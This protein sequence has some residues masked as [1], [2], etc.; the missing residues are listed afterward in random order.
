MENEN[1]ERF[2][3]IGSVA[4]LKGGTKKV[5]VTGFCSVAEENQ[6][7]IYD[8][9]GCIY[10]EGYLDFDQICLFDH[11]QIEKV[12]Y[13]GYSDEEDKNFKE[14]LKEISSKF[15]SGEQNIKTFF[16]EDIFAEDEE[17]DDE[18]TSENENNSGVVIPMIEN[19]TNKENNELTDVEELEY[20]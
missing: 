15:E 16:N 1:S 17:A 9:T 8:Y 18:E 19:D 12:F 14:E 6:E 3:P 7:K 10:P 5:M 13:V 4:L 2:L 20:L 11:D